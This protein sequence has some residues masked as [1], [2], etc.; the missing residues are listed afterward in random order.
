M[1]YEIPLFE[2]LTILGF[3]VAQAVGL[4]K[5]LDGRFR[6][7]ES[8]LESKVAERRAEMTAHTKSEDERAEKMSSEINRVDRDVTSLKARVDALPTRE[9]MS[10]M[11]DRKVDKLE[12]KFDRLYSALVRFVPPPQRLHQDD[13]N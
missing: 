1:P 11:L 2:V 13:G 3:I 8:A 4:W 12:S 7:L 6:R 10:D 5:L 9:Q